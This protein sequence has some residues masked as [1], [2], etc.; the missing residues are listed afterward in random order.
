MTTQVHTQSV[1]KPAKARDFTWPGMGMVALLLAASAVLVGKADDSKPEDWNESRLTYLPSGRLL[2]PM[3]LGQREA[4]ADLLWINAIVYFSEAYL[5]GKS[6]R[7]LGHMLDIVTTL[8]P[9]FIHAYEFGGVVLTK[10]KRE[11]P[12]TLRLL[13]R[14][15]ET[16]PK[17]WR[18]RL[19]AAMAQLSLDSNFTKAEA[20]L[21]PVSLDKDVPDHIRTMCASLLV[22]GAGTRVAL[23]FLVNRYERSDNSINR[24]IFVDKILKLYPQ[25]STRTAEHRDVVV[26]VLHEV[27]LEPRAESMGLGLL[28]EYLSNHMSPQSQR[29]LDALMQ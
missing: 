2:K 5:E 15:I 24:E 20:Y 17:D 4:A 25:D 9:Y 8:N 13:D 29:L 16:F 27:A 14:G 12:K 1:S 26:R 28:N 6:Y 3:V 19:Y 7:W 21:E 11:L 22:K 10:E 18:L 23:A